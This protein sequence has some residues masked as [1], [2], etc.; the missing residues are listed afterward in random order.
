MKFEVQD[1]LEECF[2]DFPLFLRESFSY[3]LEVTVGDKINNTL[4]YEESFSN[5][6]KILSKSF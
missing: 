2:S 4:M 1:I 3:I 5:P 6:L